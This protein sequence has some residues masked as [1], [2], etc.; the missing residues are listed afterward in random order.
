M[1]EVEKSMLLTLL[2][3]DSLC[4]FKCI[5]QFPS[6]PPP[7]YAF[8]IT[9]CDSALLMIRFNEVVLFVLTYHELQFIKAN[10]TV[11]TWLQIRMASK[12]S[13]VHHLI[14]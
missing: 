2:L 3:F 6:Y 7:T 12:F 9:S 1:I 5:S 10:Q 4:S 13:V 11:E 14:A 8:W